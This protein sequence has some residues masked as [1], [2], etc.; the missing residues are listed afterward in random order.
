M[1]QTT[2][3]YT[4]EQNGAAERLNRTLMERMRAMLEDSGLEKELW[5]EAA[6]TAC[7]IRN[8]SPVSGRDR[9]PWEL[10]FGKRPDVSGMR[11]FG[12]EAYALIPKQLRRKLDNHS[13]P[14]RVVGYP[15]ATKGYRVLLPSGKVIVS[16]DVVFVEDVGFSDTPA[17]GAKPPDKPDILEVDVQEQSDEPDEAEPDGA[18]EEEA[19]N[20]E[21]EAGDGN[22]DPGPAQGSGQAGQSRYPG[23]VRNKPSEWWRT[24]P[25][26]AAAAVIEEPFTYEEAISSD[27]SDEWIQAMDE[28]IKSLHSNETWTTE[29]IPKGKRAIPVKWVYKVKKDANGNI[30]RFKARLV[31]KGFR[32]KE[33]VDFDEVFA[34]VSKYST[35]RA[36][37]A[38][39][40]V[41]DLEVHQLDIKTA[42]LNGVLQEEVYIEQ[43]IGY[44]EGGPDIGCHLHRALYGLRQAPRAWHTRLTEEL[45][46]MG[47]KPSSADPGLHFLDTE[48]GRIFLL[49]YVDDILI[50]ARSKADV[51]WVKQ[52]LTSKFEAHDLGEAHYFLGIDIVR[53]RA[54]R[55]VKLS[56]KRLTSELV[57]KYGMGDCK[58]K[59]VPLSTA[60]KLTKSEGVPLDKSTHTYTNLIG[61]LLYLSVCTRPDI[62]QAVGVLSKYM[63]EPTSLHWQAA[64]GLLR[65][66]ASTREQS[67]VYGTEP[68]TVIGYCDADHAGDLDTRRSTTGFVFLVNG[69]A[70]TWLSKR[71][72]TVAA[73]TTEAEYIAS[74]QATK[75]A[76]WLRVLLADL[77]I[78][79]DTF[80]IMADNQSAMKLLKNPVSSMRSKHIDVVYHFARERVAR[81]E[82]EFLYIRT[83]EMLADMFTKAVPSNKFQFCCDGIGMVGSD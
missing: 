52:A 24:H 5:A 45:A 80:Q 51:E 72:P 8:R 83:D 50:A 28:E 43:P 35:L 32:Q 56:Q 68:N 19:D 57:E 54:A 66:V 65:Y 55:T 42:F 15:A 71:Q 25:Q 38:V 29:L 41:E 75:E 2:A 34:P 26:T 18:D 9:T 10:F 7:Y 39:A 48:S 53:D 77:G 6:L 67:I 59:T 37:M 76:L 73:S 4:P 79:V 31:A 82:V 74:A 36:L 78:K 58:A 49:V 33:G 81:R 17:E 44:H 64:K 40:A 16:A 3:P 12:A 63:K 13:D 70:I 47:F 20:D 11:I 1:H 27:Q 62:A 21:D 60:D 69:G 23:R 61:S 46:N 22:P 30:E 14:G